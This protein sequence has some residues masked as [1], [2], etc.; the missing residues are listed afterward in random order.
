MSPFLPSPLPRS[1]PSPQLSTAADD[2]IIDES[3]DLESEDESTAAASVIALPPSPDRQF[4]T[5]APLLPPSPPPPPPHRQRYNIGDN[6]LA[7]WARGQWYLAH[8][9]N[10]VRGTYSVYFM[11]GN[12]KINMAPMSLRPLVCANPPPTRA[13][14][15]NKVF[16]DAG[17]ENFPA[18]RWKVRRREG[19]EFV[20]VRLSP[21]EWE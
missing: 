20:C 11:D 6:V 9:T 17:D 4:Q 21:G 14:M 12:V 18:G 15:L 13:Q 3:Q 10:F 1:S 7:K 8:V 2:T 5:D 19:N 16:Y